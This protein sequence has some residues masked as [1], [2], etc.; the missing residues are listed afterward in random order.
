MSDAP[1]NN[2]DLE[3]VI[4]RAMEIDALGRPQTREAL[5]KVAAQLQI[6]PAAIDKALAEVLASGATA[7]PTLSSSS[8]DI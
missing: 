5:H 6:S 2:R 8:T 1:L 4:A 7:G 3:R